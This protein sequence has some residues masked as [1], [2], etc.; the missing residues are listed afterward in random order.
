MALTGVQAPMESHDPVR[1]VNAAGKGRYVVVCEHASNWLPAALGTL[2]LDESDMKRHIAWDPGA[3]PVARRLSEL[4][5]ATLVESCVSRLAIDCNRPLDAPDLIAEISETTR[6]PGN[7][8]LGAAAREERIALSHRPFHEA[9]E[10]V[11]QSRAA[12]GRPTWIVT[13]HSFTPIYRGV[14]R[15]WHIGI[16]HDDDDRVAAPLLA[17]LERVDG[18]VVGENEP[19]SP[20]DRVYYTLER[21]ARP[22][23]LPCAMIE[24]RNDE[25]TDAAAQ[26]RWAERLASI[27]SG[28]QE[29][30]LH[31]GMETASA[32]GNRRRA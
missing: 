1:V 4:L 27:L 32:K 13:V 2:G 22:R 20:A 7:A 28:I 29:P 15:P 6:I 17:G 12:S 11:I 30:D 23:D 16:I 19:Y 14:S 9:L 21:H 8:G 24:I 3:Q 18:I 5:D 31:L 26:E 25:I 10:K